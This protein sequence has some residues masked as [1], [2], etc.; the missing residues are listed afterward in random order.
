MIYSMWNYY[1]GDM[2]NLCSISY[3][4]NIKWLMNRVHSHMVIRC[5][6]KINYYGSMQL[7]DIWAEC[8]ISISIFPVYHDMEFYYIIMDLIYYPNAV[9]ISISERNI[10]LCVMLYLQYFN[11]D[12]KWIRRK[13]RQ[14]MAPRLGVWARRVCLG[15]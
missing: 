11:Y 2:T 3:W 7:R 10:I 4:S 5:S 6:C 13:L 14:I 1:D 8:L 9:L 12:V 15:I